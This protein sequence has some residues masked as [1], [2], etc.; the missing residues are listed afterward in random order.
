[1]KKLFRIYECDDYGNPTRYMGVFEAETKEKARA[2]AS[3]VYQTPEISST[4]FYDAEEVTKESLQNERR[5]L[6]RIMDT[7]TNIIVTNPHVDLD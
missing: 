7:K 6:Q 4:G 1:M 3:K 2:S 5:E